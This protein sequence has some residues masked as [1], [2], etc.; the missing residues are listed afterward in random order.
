VSAPD[1][2]AARECADCGRRL[3]RY[4]EGRYC[5][6]CRRAGDDGARRSGQ[7][8]WTAQSGA[9]LR[10]LRLRRGMTQETLGGLAGMSAAVISMV[11]TGTRP[12]SRFPTIL[13]LAAALGVPAAEIVPG[14]EAPAAA[15][16][17]AGLAARERDRAPATPA[18]GPQ[19]PQDPARKPR[20]EDDGEES[21]RRR[22]FLLNVAVLA[23][24]SR[25]SP[26]AAIE[27][28]RQELRR[29]FPETRE[30]DADG[31]NQI[32]LEYGETYAVT[33]PADLMGSLLVDFA[34]LQEE[35]RR[36]TGESTFRE[37]YRACALLSGFLAQTASNLGHLGESRRWWRTARYASAQAGDPYTPMWV[38]GREIV[39]GMGVLPVPALLRL[40]DEAEPFTATAPAEL[41]LEFLACKA[42]CL[43][44]ARRRPEAEHT[45]SGLRDEFS[46]SPFGGY[47]GS[48]LGWGEERL[49]STEAFT[50]SRLADSAATDRSQDA[51]SVMSKSDPA[52]VRWLAAIKLDKAYCLVKNGDISPGI[53]HAKQAITALPPAQRSHGIL[54]HG[55]DILDAIPQEAGAPHTAEYREWQEWLDGELRPT[56]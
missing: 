11:E 33:A 30:A 39:H 4:N 8:E 52:N 54:I 34:G 49:V 25:S 38:R 3:S 13:S 44:I 31:W 9:R 36:S 26:A 16:G 12:L 18:Q 6:S 41:K 51:A 23:E 32:A 2:G 14:L 29:S 17:G 43:G 42:Q 56:A 45:L 5:Q 50:Y 47:S 35:F 20:G 1:R 22:A 37:L 46:R 15:G 55:R 24:L 19:G 7:W 27:A 40:T 10:D 48:V 53:A 21:M 28:T